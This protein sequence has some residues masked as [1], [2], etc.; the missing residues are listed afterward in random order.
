[1]QVVDCCSL[2]GMFE[3]LWIFESNV[4]LV[5]FTFYRE[6]QGE[7]GCHKYEVWGRN[8]TYKTEN[9]YS[10]IKMKLFQQAELKA[11]TY[12]MI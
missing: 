4:L 2:I 10:N 11:D 7:S 8:K 1:M 6:V 9:Y 12:F 3:F 5:I